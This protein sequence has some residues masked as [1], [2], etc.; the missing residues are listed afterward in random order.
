VGGVDRVTLNPVVRIN[1]AEFVFYSA[2]L[3]E[4]VQL[5]TFDV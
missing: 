1:T 5:L 2:N 3:A 4:V